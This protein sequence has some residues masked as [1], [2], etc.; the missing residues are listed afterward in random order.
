MVTKTKRLVWHAAAIPSEVDPSNFSRN[1]HSR[2]PLDV[3]EPTT[4]GEVRGTR[5]APPR[6]AG[7]RR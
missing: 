5:N 6:D 1:T 2:D 4:F 3:K 7:A